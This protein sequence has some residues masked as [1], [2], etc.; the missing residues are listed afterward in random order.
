MAVGGHL[1]TDIAGTIGQPVFRHGLLNPVI[2]YW[3]QAATSL[4][5]WTREEAMGQVVH[6]LLRTH[7]PEPQASIE[8]QVI[9]TGAWNGRLVHWSKSG[10]RIS[11]AAFWTAQA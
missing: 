2:T 1:S 3:N 4:Y 6:E 8:R 5:G 11:V 7:F 9:A 10:A